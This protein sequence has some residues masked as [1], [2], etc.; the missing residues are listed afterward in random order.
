MIQSPME[1]FASN[2]RFK[3]GNTLPV[4]CFDGVSSP[5]QFASQTFPPERNQ[6]QAKKDLDSSE[7]FSSRSP[8][9]SPT[10]KLYGDRFIPVRENSSNNAMLFDLPEEINNQVP[11]EFYSE[12]ELNNIKYQLL[13]ENN[14]LGFSQALPQAT[15]QEAQENVPTDLGSGS[16]ILQFRSQTKQEK[17]NAY[18]SASLPL[19][20][21]LDNSF[22]SSFKAKR[23]I[24]E[25][26]FKILEAPLLEDDYYL[27]LIDWSKSNMLSVALRGSIYLWSGTNGLVTKLC[28]TYSEYEIYTGVAWD[29]RGDLLAM[30]LSDGKTEIWDPYKLKMIR[31]DLET[32][33]ERIGCLAW[34]G[35]NIL[36]TGS[37]DSNIL[38]RDLRIKGTGSTVMKFKGHKQEVCGLKWS[39]NQ[40]QLASGGNDNK[41]FIWNMKRNEPE[42]RFSDHKAAVKALTWSP[43]QNG[44]LLSGG[45]SNDKTIHVWNTLTMK[46]I[47]SVYTGSQV[48]NLLF[49]KNS[50][51]FVSTHG[52]S[53]NQVVVWKY[54]ELSKVSVLEGHTSRVLY[55]TLSPDG[56]TIV[57]GAGASDET[58]RFWCV[59]PPVT[60]NKTSNLM[61]SSL[62]LR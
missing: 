36:A 42:A 32:H 2:L 27:N 7:I 10:K 40:Y 57:T 58:L 47:K 60:R 31:N 15:T 22:F 54:P 24:P 35:S 4:S 25:K 62:N 49:S 13:L 23:K 18:G 12:K 6:F 8:S 61:P 39:P 55:L 50:N 9:A 21:T 11:S 33:M 16:R 29:K 51:E 34:E 46:N 14:V 30:G 41:L 37:R 59:F 19:Q 44:L 43:H 38:V 26:P 28:Q 56:E 5:F 1:T 45:G 3:T 20:M 53:N 17:P 52:F 48:C